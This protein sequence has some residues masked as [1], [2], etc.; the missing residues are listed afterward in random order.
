[1][2]DLGEDARGLGVREWER[3]VVLE[4]G[5]LDGLGGAITVL[6]IAKSLSEHNIGTKP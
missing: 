4:R 5:D 2:D 3:L 1:M 6:G